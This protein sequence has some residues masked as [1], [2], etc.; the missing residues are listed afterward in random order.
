VTIALHQNNRLHIIHASS[1]LDKVVI[2]EDPLAEYLKKNKSQDG[3]MIGRLV[4]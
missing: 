1:S 2:S 4:E 3:I